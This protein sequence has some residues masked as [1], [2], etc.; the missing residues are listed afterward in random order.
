M[1]ENVQSRLATA[2]SDRYSI[3]QE[4][5]SGGMAT[6][7]LA[8]DLKHDRKVAVKVLRPE[9]AASIGVDR[10]LREI[11]I[12]ANLT[13]PHILPLLDSGEAEGSLYYVMPYVEGES[14]RDRLNREKQLPVDDSLRIAGEVADALS[15][16]HAHNVIHRDI[17]P[18][19]ILREAK[20]AVV[21]D[22]GVARAIEE[23]GETKLTDTG[24]AIG[25][26]A[27][28]SPEQA[29][30]ERELDGRSDI[31]ALGCVLYEMLAGEPPFTGPTA[32]NIILKHISAEPT[33][34]NV[35]RGTVSEEIVLTVKR[36][37][38]KS[39]A[40]RFATADELAQQLQALAT[41]SGGITPSRTPPADRVTKRRWMVAGAAITVAAIIAV[42]AVVLA[43][44]GGRGV[45]LERN[46]VVVAVFRN[47]T[48]DASLDHVGE[49]AAHWIT[50]GLQ[51]AA[52]QVTPWDAALQVWQYVQ[53]EAEEGRVRD[54]TR[55]LAEETG[56][57]TVVSGVVYLENDSLEI[58]VD[59]TDMVRGRPLGAVSPTREPRTSAR[60]VIADAQQRVMGFL[61]INFDERI[62]PQARDLTQPPSYEAYRAFDDGLERYLRTDYP[63]ARSYFY[64]AFELDT[65]FVTP[66][67]YAV[68]TNF[69]LAQN[70]G[71]REAWPEADSLV[72]ILDRFKGQLSEY[73]QNW[74]GYL[75]ARVDGDNPA[76]LMAIRRA[77]ELAPGSKAVYNQALVALWVNRPQEALDALLSLDPERGEMRG[78]VPYYGYL[79]GAY[80]ALGDNEKAM[81]AG[82]KCREMYGDARFTLWYEGT[83]FALA[84]RIQRVDA[85]VDTLFALPEQS[86]A[87]GGWTMRIAAVLRRQGYINAA[88]ATIDRALEWFE[89]RPSEMKLSAVWRSRYSW[90][91]YVADRCDEAYAVMKP[92]SEES[93]EDFNHRGWVGVFAACQGDREEALEVSNWLATVDIPYSRGGPTMWRAR[94]AGTLGDGENAV[95][96][97][98]QALADGYTRWSDDLLR[99]AFE[100][101][102]DYEP[103]Q[104]LMRPKG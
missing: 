34:V 29:S 99:I 53:S 51:Q 104:E 62:S 33:P 49:R 96:F 8:H 64:Q 30:G 81:E 11:K 41:P 55:A 20:H 52:I 74:L 100:P 15:F 16:A 42:V 54:A 7:Y 102:H 80:E 6:V 26:P 69:N 72:G 25:T 38:A 39:P 18:E 92:L 23:A 66:L 79:Q 89:A 28:L 75:K 57:G 12:T 48:G 86:L 71:Q 101:I 95:A 87:P 22:F 65:T 90:A 13:H 10:F 73:Y 24:I 77:A 94:I 46:H 21:A 31:Y 50:Q 4:I 17:K 47:A 76:A 93:P 91:L 45:R 82:R 14:L 2:L 59:V 9:L 35:L 70:L 56:A 98:K 44:P 83:G 27:Y 19:N 88:R 97:F 63:E 3:E 84:G 40:D 5:G 43:I 36:A 60:E 78:F 1:T 85:V 32:E 103:W 37:L 67:V 68:L 61:A 58:H